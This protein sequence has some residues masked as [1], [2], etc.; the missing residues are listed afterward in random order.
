MYSST[1][2]SCFGEDVHPSQ[3]IYVCVSATI[4]ITQRP[5]WGLV[6]GIPQ[7]E[8]GKTCQLYEALIAH[9]GCVTS[10][11]ATSDINCITVI[12]LFS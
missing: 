8:S 12:I 4:R 6:G 11:K 1:T 3:Y 7:I 2:V 9:K 10:T 5:L